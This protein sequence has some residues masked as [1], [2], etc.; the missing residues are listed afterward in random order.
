MAG[1]SHQE[2]YDKKFPPGSDFEFHPKLREW[3]KQY[4]G[5]SDLESV[6]I[7][8]LGCDDNSCPVMETYIEATDPKFAKR[9][10]KLGK[11]KHLV[12]KMDVY[13]SIEAQKS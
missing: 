12:T 10:L 2:I 8:E 6:A 11:A 13:F 3:L 5:L 9:T 1:H 4:W 7:K